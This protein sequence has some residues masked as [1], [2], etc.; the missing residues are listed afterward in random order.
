[1]QII[2]LSGGSGQR[3]WPLSNKELSKQF[4]KIL[5]SA[6]NINESMIQRVVRQIEENENFDSITIATGKEHY[7]ILKQQIHSKVNIVA[8]PERRDTFPAIALSTMFLLKEQKCSL[9]EV[10]VVMPCDPYVEKDYFDTLLEMAEVVSN[11][12]SNMVLMGIKPTSSSSKYGYILT[13]P[14]F[15]TSKNVEVRSFCEKPDSGTA[16]L[17]I[18][19]G[20]LLEYNCFTIPC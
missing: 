12:I 17:L 2:L 6:S 16:E 14:S 15:S 11:N 4:L 20:A 9:D 5:P 19:N 13:E 10:V 18:K 3:L 8:E 1:M 7:K